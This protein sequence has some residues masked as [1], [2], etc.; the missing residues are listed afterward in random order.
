MHFFYFRE[1]SFVII[2]LAVIVDGYG[3]TVDTTGLKLHYTGELHAMFHRMGSEAESFYRCINFMGTV[4]LEDDDFL[5]CGNFEIYLKE[6]SRESN[7][8]TLV[9]TTNVRVYCG[10][11][12]RKV[13]YVRELMCFKTMD[14][15]SL[16][17][18]RPL[19][20]LMSSADSKN[21]KTLHYKE[22]K[23]GTVRQYIAQKEPLAETWVRSESRWIPGQEFTVVPGVGDIKIMLAY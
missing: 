2:L 22:L 14:E 16:L 18:R 9:E 1:L 4:S 8:I 11:G 7:D 10:I 13:D 15:E 21:K 20:Y 5:T 3:N 12:F 6:G 23:D 19:V 17:V